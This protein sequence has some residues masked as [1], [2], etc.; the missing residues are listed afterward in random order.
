MTTKSKELLGFLFVESQQEEAKP[1]RPPDETV[2]KCL[3]K[4]KTE[5]AGILSK[6]GIKDVKSRLGI[7]AG[8]FKLCSD[9]EQH[10][11]DSSVLFDMTKIGPLAS[12][13]FVA[14]DGEADDCNHIVIISVAENGESP[15]A[16]D[17]MLEAPTDE[18]FEAQINSTEKALE[19][20]EQ[21]LKRS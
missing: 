9:K 14:I 3:E 5:L 12:A 13:N 11:E 19:L 2:L 17:E 18:D 4:R 20:I 10:A 21:L 16:V 1:E 6:L 7:E 8:A 15:K